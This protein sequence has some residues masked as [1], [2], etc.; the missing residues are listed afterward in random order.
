M[1]IRDRK[2]ETFG[3]PAWPHTVAKLKLYYSGSVF[4]FSHYR[5]M[6]L[7]LAGEWE[8]KKQDG[9]YNTDVTTL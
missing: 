7:I 6:L 9:G 5:K 8:L 1:H 4:V 3:N 2:A